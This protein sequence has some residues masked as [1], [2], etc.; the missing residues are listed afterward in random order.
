MNNINQ[1]A[2]STSANHESAVPE[3][4]DGILNEETLFDMSMLGD[5]EGFPNMTQTKVEPES[6]QV[7]SHVSVE[8][9]LKM[10]F[11]TPGEAREF[12][13]SYSRLKGFAIRNSKTVKNAKGDI[14]RYN[15]VCNREGFR[16]K[17]W[18]D[19]PDRKREYKPIMRCGYV[20]EMRI[21]KNHG[22]GKWYVSQ[23]VDDHNHT[24]LPERFIGYLPSHR[25]MSDV[26]IAQ[27]NSMRQVG[28]SI[29]KI[30]QSF[31]MQSGD[32]NAALRFFEHAARND[33]RLFW[34]YE[35]AAGSRMCDI[36]WSD[37]R[38]QEDYEAFGDVLAFD[39]TY[40]R[41][42]YNLP[43][44]VLSG[45]NHHNQTCVFAA[46]MV[47]CESQDSYKWV[48][49]RFLECMRG[50][51]P[52]AFITDGDPSMRLAIMHVFPD[53][54][55]RLCAWHLLRNATAHVSQPRFTQLF[56]QCMLADIEVHEFE[57]QWEAMVG[58][59]GVREV[60][61][62]MDL[63]SKK[64]SWATA[65]IRGRFFTGLRTTSR[66]ESLHAKLGGF[67]ESR[68]GI[69]DFIT[70]FQRC[71]DFL[72]DKEEELD[73]RSF[74]G[75]P[76]LQTHF[77]E[78]E[79]SAAT[80]YTREV[81]YRFRE[82]L[83]RVVRFNIIDREDCENG[84]C[85]VIQK[86]RRPESTW[87]VLHQPQNGTFECNCH[88]MESYGIL[89]VHIIFVL[90]GIDIGYLPET[91]VLKRWCRNAKNNVTFV[92]QVTET[93]DAASRYHSRLGAFVDQC[94]RLAKVACLRE[95]DYKVYSEKMARDVVMLEVKN[96]LR[97]AADVN[98]QP[99]GEGGGGINDPVRVRTKGTGRG[100]VSQRTKGPKKRKC[101]ACGK[102]GHRR[103]RCPI[104]ADLRPGCRGS[105]RVPK[106]RQAEAQATPSQTTRPDHL[107]C[108]ASELATG[109]QEL[110][111]GAGT[112]KRKLRVELPNT[113]PQFM[114]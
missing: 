38:S 8:D 4:E 10:E 111:M 14:V 75:T 100:N 27:M 71:V 103:T 25:N 73:F 81:F 30:Y 68:Y 22:N 12:Y 43:V 85:Y 41:N 48:L 110:Q 83:K 5:E 37:G 32:V 65:Y 79:R 104:G 7:P 1:E 52:K 31:A 98:T 108:F 105:Q 17:K 45:V 80:L 28:I 33:E 61:W 107:N 39:A 112:R 97:V 101:S 76:V 87:Q 15:F 24:L 78:I 58:E 113:F 50:K 3:P 55:H 11:F 93:G 91:L 53:A 63:Y 44:I 26:E 84:C 90:V 54:H 9:V 86:Y 29:P 20:A 94:K 99:N 47:S 64:L 21:K 62:V 51:A 70:N 60:E 36:I 13:T 109:Q 2:I 42:K 77:Q 114:S 82:T 106:G 67:V 57:R 40:G 69:L 16:Q 88:R 59:C 6:A 72:R 74:Y 95:E 89:C 34:R 56:K 96:G 66:C 19:K 49:R 35:V 102:L 46:A 18:L 92:R 23:F